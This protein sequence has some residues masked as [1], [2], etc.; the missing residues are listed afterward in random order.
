[1]AFETLADCRD[2]DDDMIAEEGVA[3]NYS[4]DVE[5]PGEEIENENNR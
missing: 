5:I 1:V 3:H 4:M 2:S